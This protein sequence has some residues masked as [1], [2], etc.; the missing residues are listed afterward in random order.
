MIWLETSPEATRLQ[1]VLRSNQKQTNKQTNKQKPQMRKSVKYVICLQA[2][3]FIMHGC[4]AR[5]NIN[6][7]SITFI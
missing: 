2:C 4:N 5:P 6:V 1:V 7:V 3:C